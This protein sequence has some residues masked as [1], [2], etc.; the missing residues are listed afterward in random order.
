[1]DPA[2]A[3]AIQQRCRCAHGRPRAEGRAKLGGS[4][5]Y[6][7]EDLKLPPARSDR[8][9]TFHDPGLLKRSSAAALDC[10]LR[11]PSKSSAC[12]TRGLLLEREAYGEYLLGL[13]RIAYCCAHLASM[14]TWAR[15]DGC[16]AAAV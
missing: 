6:V 4:G 10:S 15:S 1:M 12:F 3:E 16:R 13:Y 2:A 7:S 8:Y 9:Y 11:P 14:G 5:E